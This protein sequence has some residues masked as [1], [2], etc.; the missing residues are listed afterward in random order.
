MGKRGIPRREKLWS[1][2]RDEK[3]LNTGRE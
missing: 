1:K 2:F 3:A